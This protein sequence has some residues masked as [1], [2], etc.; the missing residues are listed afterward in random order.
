ME[1]QNTNDNT[2]WLRFAS[3]ASV[4]TAVILI[5]VKAVA[6]FFTGSVSLLA[7]LVDSVL[8][9]LASVINWVAIRYSLK[10]ADKEHRFGHGKA[11]SLAGLVQAAFILVSGIFLVLN[12]I[13]HLK[14]QFVLES[15]WL[16]IGVIVFAILATLG[17]L[18]IQ[19]TAIKKTG[20]VAIKADSLH[21]RAD[22]LSNTAVLVALG[23]TAW[24]WPQADAL[25]AIGIAGYMVYSARDIL[26]E[27][28]NLL[29]DHELPDVTR[30]QITQLILQVEGVK[31][32]HQL[33]TRRSGMTPI[34][35]LHLEL[36]KH[37]TLEAAHQISDQ[38]DAAI[39]NQFP[40]ADILIHQDPV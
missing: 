11:E 19:Y 28:I 2:F 25:I 31:G 7:S 21:Y 36:D 4:I 35:Q 27:A 34:I 29:M 12:A 1:I 5:L 23:L 8:D 32:V 18:T 38:V 16:G 30:Q 9:G 33:R 40:D 13:H 37:L 3:A 24:G 15:E 20:S 17:L 26:I 14:R 10:P 22:L 39:L 6:W